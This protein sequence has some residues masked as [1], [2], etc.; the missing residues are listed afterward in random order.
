MTSAVP[1]SVECFHKGKKGKEGA[2]RV[3]F[4]RG[5]SFKKMSENLE[6]L[7]NPRISPMAVDAKMLFKI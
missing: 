6:N 5:T 4:K 2:A 7:I 1:L 3:M